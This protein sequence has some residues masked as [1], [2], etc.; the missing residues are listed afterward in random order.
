[1][2][3]NICAATN[4]PSPCSKATTISSTN[5]AP[6][7]TSS[8]TIPNASP[9]SHPELGRRSILEA[10]GIIGP[11]DPAVTVRV[12]IVGRRIVGRR[13]V[14]VLVKMVVPEREPAVAKAAAVENIRG[15]KPGAMKHRAAASDDAAM[16]DCTAAFKTSAAVETVTSTAMTAV[17]FGRQ[18]VGGVFR[19]RR[20]TS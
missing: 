5:P 18:P 4:S 9:Q 15:S 1:M 19:Y 7:G 2:S 14:E 12:I 17:D 10:V 13:I 8:P 11:D 6:H 20:S 16:K 3:G